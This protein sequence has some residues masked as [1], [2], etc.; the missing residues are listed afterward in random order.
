M[1]LKLFDSCCEGSSDTW[2]RGVLRWLGPLR[3]WID[4]NHSAHIRKSVC[5]LAPRGVF[6]DFCTPFS[7][8]PKCIGK[9]QKMDAKLYKHMTRAVE[10]ACTDAASDEMLA[11]T[12]LVRSQ[13]SPNCRLTIRDKTHASRRRREG[14][15]VYA[16]VCVLEYSYKP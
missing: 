10:M 11:T 6:K 1:K 12:L 5:Y 13:I 7:G 16:C 9:P 15:Y 14:G 4:C 3:P 8:A 2:G